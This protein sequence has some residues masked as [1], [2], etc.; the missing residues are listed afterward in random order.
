MRSLILLSIFLALNISSFSQV[1]DLSKEAEKFKKFNIKEQIQWT[2]KYKGG[3]PNEEGRKNTISKFDKEG[4]LI[5]KTSFN[6]NGEISTIFK[7]EYD[8]EGRKILSENQDIGSGASYKQTITYDKNNQKIQEKIESKTSAG[9]NKYYLKYIYEKNELVEI[10]KIN[11]ISSSVEMT[12]KYSYKKNTTTIEE[13]LQGKALTKTTIKKYN[14]NDQIIEQLVDD[15]KNNVKIKT[16]FEYDSNG[17]NIS[18]IEYRNNVKTKNQELQY[19]NNNNL[20]AILNKEPDGSS[21]VNNKYKYN[22][23]QELEEELWYEGNPDNYSKKTLT[24]DEDGIL[25]EINYYYAL[26]RYQL[27]Y[28]F[29]YNK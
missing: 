20:V 3:Q 28:R 1:E 23:Q 10:K 9:S 22:S 16:E 7:Y 18:Q 4:F 5:E 8:K 29:T 25:R 14:S 21:Y 26:Y 12:W 17:N 19:D 15:T 6:R 24:Y 11:L 2:H 13:Y 27:L